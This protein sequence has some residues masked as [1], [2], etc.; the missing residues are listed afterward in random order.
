MITRAISSHITV[1]A[2][3]A[4]LAVFAL[5]ACAPSQRSL[6]ETPMR[7]LIEQGFDV[8]VV[9]D[10]TAAAKTPALGDGYA[11]AL[12]NFGFI[13]NG[14]VTTEQAVALLQGSESAVANK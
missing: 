4:L 1:R 2:V 3:L 9:K 11:S 5:S 13:A 14:V 12:I 6:A 8:T 7:E 10:A